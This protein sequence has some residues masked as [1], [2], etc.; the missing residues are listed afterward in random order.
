MREVLL[1][2][3]LLAVVMPVAAG[4]TEGQPEVTDRA[5]QTAARVDILAAWVENEPEGVRFTV[6]VRGFERLTEE[7]AFGIGFTVA[8]DTR[9]IAL[10]L[11]DEAG[12]THT[13]VDRVGFGDRYDG[14]DEWP[15]N[16]RHVTIARGA[17]A[18][19]SAVIPWGSVPGFEPGNTMNILYAITDDETTPTGGRDH[20]DI[21][22]SGR[23]FALRASSTSGVAA[24]APPI[25][26][27]V[28]VVV[29]GAAGF[30]LWRRQRQ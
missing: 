30:V 5:D 28:A 19:V 22:E 16:L 15:N 18:Y 3:A 24:W 26:L 20:V 10:V 4:G 12:G 27:G 11:I 9:R 17:P 13:I 1:G 8:G 29:G 14:A 25:A 6:K 7:V 2:L 23:S 21:A